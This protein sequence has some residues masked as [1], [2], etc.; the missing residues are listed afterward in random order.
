MIISV[1]FLVCYIYSLQKQQSDKEHSMVNEN[2][3]SCTSTKV[4]VLMMSMSAVILFTIMSVFHHQ[5]QYLHRSESSVSSGLK[6]M[7]KDSDS[8]Y[9]PLVILTVDNAP[10]ILSSTIIKEAATKTVSSNAINFE[11]LERQALKDFY[12]S[13]DGTYWTYYYYNGGGDNAWDFSDP[14]VNPCDQNWYGIGC[15]DNHI[16]SITLQRNGL[17]GS[18]PATIGQ[19][20]NLQTF[21]LSYNQVFGIIP[22]TIGQLSLLQTLDLSNSPL[23]GTIPATLGQLSYLQKLDLSLCLLTG[24]IPQ[25]IGQLS[26][27]QILSLEYNHLT[28][29]IPSTIGQLSTLLY[30]VLNNNQL[31]ASS[32]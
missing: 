7:S 13:T 10:R 17:L 12:D 25:S 9:S 28:G 2:P 31:M 1:E 14:S 8:I 15:S 19:L 16:I 26:S 24:T 29:T 23:T 20:P 4:K 6:S 27:L 11:P 30:L 32:Q 22:T 3:R 18:I 21:V 5:Q